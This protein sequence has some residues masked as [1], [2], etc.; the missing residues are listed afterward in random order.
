M[1]EA[2]ASAPRARQHGT[3][4]AT[5]PGSGCSGAGRSIAGAAAWPFVLRPSSFVLRPSSF[6]LRPSSCSTA[7]AAGRLRPNRLR[8]N[9]LRPNRLRPNRLHPN[10]LRPNRLRP[11]RLVAVA[12]AAWERRWPHG[13]LASLATVTARGVPPSLTRGRPL[14]LARGRP[15]ASCR[16]HAMWCSGGCRPPRPRNPALATAL[17]KRPRPDDR[18]RT[19]SSRPGRDGSV[20]GADSTETGGGGG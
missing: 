3:T 1:A 7:A 2:E 18:Y 5:A 16:S 13:G 14:S 15:S 8:P 20:P 11:N 9:R 19:T 10:R 4:S 6:V 12:V 17:G